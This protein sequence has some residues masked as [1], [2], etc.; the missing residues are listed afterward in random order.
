MRRGL[1]AAPGKAE[2]N[3][4]RECASLQGRAGT[5][6]AAGLEPTNPS[7][8]DGKGQAPA[9]PGTQASSE[10]SAKVSA[11]PSR[12][13]R[14]LREAPGKRGN[15]CLEPQDPSGTSG[16]GKAPAPLDA[17]HPSGSREEDRA[18]RPHGNQTPFGEH[19]GK[20]DNR[21]YGNRVPFGEPDGSSGK[22][23]FSD[24]QDLSGSCGNELVSASMIWKQPSGG[25]RVLSV[26]LQRP[27]GRCAPRHL[28][29]QRAAQ[30]SSGM[31][32][33]LRGW[34]TRIGSGIFSPSGGEK[35]SRLRPRGHW[36]SLGLL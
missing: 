27:S 2:H 35:L 33:F 20:G 12:N 17:Q 19:G 4:L 21:P 23:A 3:V 22:H 24:R 1:R 32:P 15:A 36:A 25:F 30:V 26:P 9:D 13:Q 5:L 16:E 8:L 14:I 31:F 29:A 28:R 6:D 18:N 7:G 10:A 11:P 34:S